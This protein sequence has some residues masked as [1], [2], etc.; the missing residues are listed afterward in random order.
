M[1][2][3]VVGCKFYTQSDFEFGFIQFEF[4]R[5]WV[6]PSCGLLSVQLRVKTSLGLHRVNNRVKFGIGLAQFRFGYILDQINTVW[7]QVGY[8]VGQIFFY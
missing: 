2:R 6:L 8:R 5:V 1:G 3:C 4:S 7:A